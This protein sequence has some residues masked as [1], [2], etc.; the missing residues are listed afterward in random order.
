MAG[1]LS[2]FFARIADDAA[3]GGPAGSLAQATLSVASP[4]YAVGAAINRLLHDAGIQQRESLP[5][6][7]LS[8]GNITVGGTG[9][10]PFCAWLVE[11]LRAEGKRPAVLTRGYGRADESRLVVVHNGSRLLART[12]DGGDEPVMLARM[13]GDV[14]VVACAD[15]A[16]G[17][18]Y[19]LK[20]F[21]IDTLVLDD[22]FQHHDLARQGDILLVDSTRPISSLR[23]LPRGTLRELPGV[24][25]RAHLIVMTRWNQASSPKRTLREVMHHAPGVPVA[26]MS[27][28]ATGARRLAGGELLPLDALKGKRAVVLTGVANPDSVRA[29]VESA[30]LRVAKLRSLGDHATI[31]RQTLDAALRMMRKMRA[32]FVVVTEKD[33]AKLEELGSLP[34]QIIALKTELRFVE[35]RDRRTAEKALRARV[36]ARGVRGLLK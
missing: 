8:V 32:E 36:Q 1:T 31:T 4:F 18:R 11:W 6:I 9:K 5:T 30:G 12:T 16:R 25:S 35:E 19:A 13:L 27:L 22:G 20:K 17:G 24:L 34:P 3:P 14:P 23:L 15:R 26:R 2:R 7:V 29:S 10:S 33:A 28:E 21:E